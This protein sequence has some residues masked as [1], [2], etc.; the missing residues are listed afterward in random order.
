MSLEYN[1]YKELK[2]RI[3]R[4]PHRTGLGALYGLMIPGEVKKKK[5][6][7]RRS[8]LKEGKR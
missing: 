8:K 7:D 2:E 5:D 6:T 4:L 1:A 3:G